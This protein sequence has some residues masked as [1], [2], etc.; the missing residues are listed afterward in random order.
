MVFWK[1]TC[2]KEGIGFQKR[3]LRKER[4]NVRLCGLKANKAQGSSTDGIIVVDEKEANNKTGNF[5]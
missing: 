2:T 5:N 3:S 4:V 1:V